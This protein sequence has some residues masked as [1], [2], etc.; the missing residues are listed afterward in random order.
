MFVLKIK[1]ITMCVLIPIALLMLYG[2]GDSVSI[3]QR[4]KERHNYEAGVK[5]WRIE[6]SVHIKDWKW[7]SKECVEIY[8]CY[9]NFEEDIDLVRNR[10]Y[11]RALIVK[12][13]L[14]KCFDM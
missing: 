2:C 11:E 6:T 3:I 13:K 14:E 5:R 12:R 10:Q 8:D 9:V 4:V 7:E 1:K